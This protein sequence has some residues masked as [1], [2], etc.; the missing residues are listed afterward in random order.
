MSPYAL[1][2]PFSPLGGE[3]LSLT[4]KTQNACPG[5]PICLRQPA[6]S[7]AGVPEGARSSVHEV[8][9]PDCR[10]GSWRSGPPH[11]RLDLCGLGATRL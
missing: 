10:P 11:G 6:G 3:K 2:S 1:F 4:L 9:K 5:S 7:W 8:V